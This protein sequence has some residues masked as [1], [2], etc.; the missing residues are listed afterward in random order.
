MY[1]FLQDGHDIIVQWTSY[2]SLS[3]IASNLSLSTSFLDLGTGQS[4]ASKERKELT[5]QNVSNP[6]GSNRNDSLSKPESYEI[7]IPLNQIYSIKKIVPALGSGTPYIIISTDTGIALPPLY[8]T[9][10]GIKEMFTALKS[11]AYVTR[12]D[13][14][15]NLFLINDTANML[16]KSMT[17]LE[18]TKGGAQDRRGRNGS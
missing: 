17:S 18:E 7:K 10:G 6:A 16:V 12:S 13:E 8:F 14:D 1:F 5:S 9:M 4:V 2:A 15:S 3:K 11:C